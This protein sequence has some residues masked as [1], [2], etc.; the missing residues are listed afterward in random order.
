MKKAL[1]KQKKSDELYGDQTGIRGDVSGICGDVTDIC[2]DVDDCEL[3][4]EERAE[5]INI[6]DLVNNGE[7]T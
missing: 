4:Y 2:G 7:E 5:G 1:R 6:K 3:S